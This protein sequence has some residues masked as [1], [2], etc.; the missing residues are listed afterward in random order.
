MFSFSEPK[1]VVFITIVYK[2][3]THLTIISF[4]IDA[5]IQLQLSKN[6]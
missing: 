4:E 3:D 6:G 1:P 5:A 2:I